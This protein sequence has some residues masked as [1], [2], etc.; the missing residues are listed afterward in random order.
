MRRVILD[1]AA[2]LAW[3]E[4]AEA[5][6]LRSEYED[7]LLGVVAPR[8][9]TTDL[10]SNLAASRD[11]PADRLVRIAAEVDRLGFEIRE[12][13]VD[14]IAAWLARGLPANLAPYTALASALDLPLITANPELLRRAASVARSTTDG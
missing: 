13:P 8:Q 7:G 4:G 3:F 11:W 1:A 10:L 14:E 12:P 2:L 9:L 6:P 5:S